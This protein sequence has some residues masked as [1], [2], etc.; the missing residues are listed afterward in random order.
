MKF[1]TQSQPHLLSATPAFIP[2]TSA[3]ANIGFTTH[4]LGLDE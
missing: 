3:H 4:E 1:S 2:E